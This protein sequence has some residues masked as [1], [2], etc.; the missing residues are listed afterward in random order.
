MHQ[1][2]HILAV[3]DNVDI[4]NLIQSTFE[5]RGQLAIC[6]PSSQ[7]A[8][9]LL[10]RG[11]QAEIILF[12]ANA[13]KLAP[14][15]SPLGLFEKITDEKLCVLSGPS[16]TSWEH[17]AAKCGIATTLTLPLRRQDIEN[18]S[19]KTKEYASFQPSTGASQ[20]SC[21][22]E[23]LDNNRFFLAAS[24]PMMKLYRD[25][26]AL[27]PVDIPVLILGESGVGKE[28]V[29]MLL[30]KYH[31][32]A[33]KTFL[34]VNCAALPTELLESELFGYEAGAFTGA[35][36]AKPGKFE[37]ANKGTLLLDEIGEMSSQMQAKL[38]HVLQD[39]S[40][41]RLGA[42]TTTQVDVRT[43]AAT[44]IN[45]EEAIAQKRFREDLYYRLNTL[46]L[47]VPPLR[48][49]REEIPLLIEQM[50]RRGSA[51]LGQPFA[52]SRRL[53]E[54]AQD[55]HWPGNV[56]ELRNFVTR[57]LI[58]QDERSAYNDLHAKIRTEAPCTTAVAVEVPIQE[59]KAAIPVGMK[60]VI[61][62]VK[63]QAEIR[64]L[65]DALL[66]SG[67]NRRRAAINLNISYRSL[68]YKIQRHGLT[69]HHE[70]SVA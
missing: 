21:H 17:Y 64:M 6:V 40:F 1:T 61:S 11:I 20:T 27:A 37:L 32:R 8:I 42:R 16:D 63:N 30:H 53:I 7:E 70:S 22:L 34:N 48:E 3:S 62:D 67:W 29:A 52:F 65:Q 26:R 38:L 51:E 33:E 39:G 44:N 41:C 14:A 45:M 59:K 49:R 28:V 31:A 24:S 25:V 19:E 13:N 2:I 50:T 9:H 5:A 55:Y 66:A 56:R 4:R 46:T 58:L 10:N 23:E 47:T 35:T 15:P 54:T 69:A 18:L 57:T 12:D 36:K 60:D 43:L 68:L